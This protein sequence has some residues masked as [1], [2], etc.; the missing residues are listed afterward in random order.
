[1][2][3]FIF[4]QMKLATM[5]RWTDDLP[6]CTKSGVGFQKNQRYRPGG[7]RAEF[8]EN[9]DGSF[10]FRHPSSNVG[11]YAVFDGHDGAVVSNYAAQRVSA[12][13]LLDKDLEG[14]NIY[15][16]VSCCALFISKSYVLFQVI[17]IYELNAH[18]NCL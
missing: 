5:D 16:N 13:L 8:H 10:N 6:V 3:P 15:H 11:V 12:E 7:G 9:E 18:T 14:I 4:L 1:M 17:C 2:L